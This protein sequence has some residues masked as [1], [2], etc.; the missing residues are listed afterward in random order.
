[1]GGDGLVLRT[2]NQIATQK[3]STPL[4]RVNFG[5][6]G[7]LTNVEPGE[8]FDR[9]QQV[10]DKKFIVTKRLRIEVAVGSKSKDFR[11]T[12]IKADALN[13]IVI[14]RTQTRAVLF[15]I[16]VNQTE[17]I[18]I[19]GDG[20]IFATRTGSTAYNR[21]VGGPILIKEDKFVLTVVSPT[22]PEKTFYFVRP[23]NS[24]FQINKIK[25]NT[26]VVV[27]GEEL[28]KLSNNDL[29]TIKKSPQSTFFIE[30]G[31]A[32]RNL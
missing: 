31:D 10:F 5:K 25:G 17:K 28:L 18:E 24:V 11:R 1:L 15:Q 13:E 30:F 3:L 8:V 22:D 20:I 29:P 23:A 19:A 14:E 9:L 16:I 21:N 26:R 4:F 2:A 32:L 7:F 12:E 6:R 27:D